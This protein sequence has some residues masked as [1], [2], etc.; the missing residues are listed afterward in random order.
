MRFA[1]DFLSVSPIQGKVAVFLPF[2]FQSIYLFRP[3]IY[4]VKQCQMGIFSLEQGNNNKFAGICSYVNN[5]HVAHLSFK[6][7]KCV[8]CAK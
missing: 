2:F 1:K 5:N 3:I 8:S 4:N 7:C 6:T